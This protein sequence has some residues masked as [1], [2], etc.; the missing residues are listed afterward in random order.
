MKYADID[1]IYRNLPLD[2]IP[3]NSET[4]PDALVDLVES[5]KVLPCRAVDLGCGAG[6]YAIYLAAHGFDMTGVDSSPA[7]VKIATGNARRLGVRCRFIIADLIGDLHEV[8]ERFD[9]A[10]DWEFLHHIFP[11]DRETYVRNVAK[12]LNRGALYLSVSFSETDPQF[13]G[14]GKFRTTPIGTT[15]YF[16]SESELRDLF[17]PFFLIHE[18]KTIEV[19]GRFGPHRAVY[20]LSG[21]R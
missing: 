7:A 19:I 11:D 12:I 13:G 3:W 4:P 20:V 21:R 10:F 17:S 14:T 9:F 15:L 2:K 18:L 1:R 5:R 8:Q 16:S 6:N